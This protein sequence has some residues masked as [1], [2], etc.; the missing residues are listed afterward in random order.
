MGLVLEVDAQPVSFFSYGY[1]L[2]E[3][4]DLVSAIQIA[5]LL[6][7]GLIKLD[8]IPGRGV[9]KDFCDLYFV[10]SP[11]SLDELFGRGAEKHPLSQGFGM[12]VLTALVDFD[13]A[14]QQ[15]E[16]TLLLPVGWDE[17]KA[18]F[19]AEARCLGQE[20]FSLTDSDSD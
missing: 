9:R 5:G 13:I 1:P 3:R 10:A 15:D 16:P 6:D 7:I 14:N 17:V 18:F 4:T 20:W 12:R 2:S 19:E 8:A 11:V